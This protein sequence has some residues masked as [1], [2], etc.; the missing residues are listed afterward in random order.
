[1]SFR[2]PLAVMMLLLAGC[3]APPPTAPVEVICP[4]RWILPADDASPRTLRELERA[5]RAA[6][7]REAGPV[8]RVA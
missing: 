3:T 8:P 4:P 1:M 6:L 5:W 2:L 7:I